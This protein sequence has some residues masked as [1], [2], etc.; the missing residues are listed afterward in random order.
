MN[1]RSSQK[2]EHHPRLIRIDGRVWNPGHLSEHFSAIA[3][4]VG[5]AFTAASAATG[6]TQ[7]VGL[8]FTGLAYGLSITTAMFVANKL[9]D[10]RI[11]TQ[12][13]GQKRNLRDYAIDREGR[14]FPPEENAMLLKNV[15][16]IYKPLVTASW[17][18]PAAAFAIT[19]PNTI[20]ISAVVPNLREALVYI[21]PVLAMPS[22]LAAHMLTLRHNCEK[23]LSTD[24]DRYVFRSNNGDRPSGNAPVL[25]ERPVA[26]FSPKL[27]R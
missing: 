17:A 12:P 23:L 15:E 2:K 22:M 24:A 8:L 21:L 14:S 26:T 10:R 25:V 6:A 16:M 3:T 9:I 13:A 1:S 5:F 18:I 27:H 19:L 20:L 4:Q 11:F 7:N